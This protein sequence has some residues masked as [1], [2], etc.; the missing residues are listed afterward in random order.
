MQ[1]RSRLVALAFACTVGAVLA[2]SLVVGGAQKDD[3]Q[4]TKVPCPSTGPN[5]QTGE[6]TCYEARPTPFKGKATAFGPYRLLPAG[7]AFIERDYGSPSDATAFRDITDEIEIRG[8][9][10]YLKPPA[11]FSEEG[12]SGRTQHGKPLQVWAVWT[13]GTEVVDVV[14]TSHPEGTLPLDV[15]LYPPSSRLAIRAEIIE[16]LYAIVEEPTASP[17]PGVGYV[18][19]WLGDKEVSLHSTVADQKRLREIAAIVAR[20]Q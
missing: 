8:W 7:T 14:V 17:A 1:A 15:Y 2:A 4:A 18:S 11:G 20:E 19:I 12:L 3:S 16:G 6:M 5:G 9:T 13:N 10:E